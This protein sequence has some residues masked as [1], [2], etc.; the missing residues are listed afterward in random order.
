MKKSE[1]IDFV[2]FNITGDA[3]NYNRCD[4]ESLYLGADVFNIFASCF[5]RSNH[6]FDFVAPTLYNSR[7]FIPLRNELLV[8][9][10][11][12][13]AINNIAQFQSYL[14]GIFLGKDLLKVLSDFDPTYEKHWRSH[15][16]KIIQVNRHLMRLVDMCIEEE[17][18][19]WVIPY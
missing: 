15:M 6:L 9:L 3:E 18:V 16:R 13:L 1:I 10:E 19:L 14:S 7:K 4:D 2:E 8:N 12:L 17:R 5:E 11:T